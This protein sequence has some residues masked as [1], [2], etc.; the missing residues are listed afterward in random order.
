MTSDNTLNILVC[1]PLS[2]EQQ[3][4][5]ATSGQLHHLD[6]PDEKS[7]IPIIHQY[8][9]LLVDSQTYVSGQII[10]EGYNLRV[11]GTLDPRL[12][13][14]DVS[15]ARAFG[16]PV[17]HTPNS[18][19]IAVAEQTFALLL[20]LAARDPQHAGLAGKTLGLVGFGPVSQEV[21]RRAKAFEMH[22][23]VNQPR[24]TPQL[25][26]EAGVE[27]FDLTDLLTTADFVSLHVPLKTETR[28]LISA[29]EMNLMKPS[30]YLLSTTHAA[31]V[32][33]DDLLEALNQKNLAGVAISPAGPESPHLRQHPLVLTAP[34]LATPNEDSEQDIIAVIRKMREILRTK[35]A[36]ETL[37]LDVVPADLVIPH[38]QI[39]DKRVNRLKDRLADEGS[40]VNPP[41]VTP[42]KGQYVV[43]DGA[44]RTT[45]LRRL[46]YP[47][48]I[49][50]VVPADQEGFTLH[51]WYH[52]INSPDPENN[53][54]TP[55]T[56]IEQLK[57]IEGLTLTTVN[58][59]QLPTIFNDPSSLCYFLTRDN[60]LIFAQ[61]NP[62]TDRLT[63]MNEIV[64][65]YT[66]W[67]QVERT[68]LSD[69]GRLLGQFPHMIATAVFPQFTPDTVFDVATRGDLMPAGLTRFVIP[70]RILRLNADLQRL[71]Q[72]EPLT[73]K[74]AWFNHFLE[75]KLARSRLRYY[76]EP[77]IIL[78][79]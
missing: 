35:R 3:T 21:A 28:G 23:I 54:I 32:D 70:G 47:H 34:P 19:A 27:L 30:A 6:Q 17:C 56:L 64:A 24:L 7:L 33:D 16:I 58:T 36:S 44:T 40:L 42:W 69:L 18:N 63:V 77:V 75:E 29:P 59:D 49:V 50:Q 57:S 38:E 65:H 51:T 76:Q 53:T 13:N 61:A 71:K 62:G 78:D 8:D 9:A 39:D 14:I 11:I 45:A 79:E 15:A 25:A 37:S 74:K 55:Q 46:G 31:L 60:Q 73:A 48:M 67:G 20:M 26:L 22:V 43:L 68:L 4:I 2:T 72:D 52:A 1:T 41:L 66:N 10:E 5:L 12:D